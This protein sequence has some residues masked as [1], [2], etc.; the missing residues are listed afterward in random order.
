MEKREL[1]LKLTELYVANLTELARD[2]QAS[3]RMFLEG[4]ISIL[5]AQEGMIQ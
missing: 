3:S 1:I 4:T 2:C 5:V